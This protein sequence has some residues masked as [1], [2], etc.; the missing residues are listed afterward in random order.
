MTNLEEDERLY[1]SLARRMLSPTAADAARVKKGTLLAVANANVTS[2]SAPS[3]AEAVADEATTHL[4]RK[5]FARAFIVSAVAAGAAAAGYVYG[6]DAGRRQTIAVPPLPRWAAPS[7]IRLNPM[8][9]LP[10]EVLSAA[11][12]ASGSETAVPRASARTDEPGIDELALLTQVDRALREQRPRDALSLLDGLEH[13]HPNKR[14]DEERAALHVLAECDLRPAAEA[15]VLALGFSQR[16]P[17]S[18]YEP[19]VLRGCGAPPH[20]PSGSREER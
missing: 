2:G 16:H 15:R 14:F 11:P 8:P 5:W 18:V 3:A 12:R 7:A 19:R 17:G 13:G 9:D 20:D 4:A 6:L 1:L 10:S